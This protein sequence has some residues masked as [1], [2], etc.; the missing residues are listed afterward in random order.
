MSDLYDA[1]ASALQA[2]VQQRQ[3]TDWKSILANSLA[4]GAKGAMQGFAEAKPN[5]YG[6]QL[7]GAL[8][9]GLATGYGQQRQNK[10]ANQAM[11]DFASV[12][13]GVSPN[14]P[15]DLMAGLKDKGFNNSGNLAAALTLTDFENRNN[16]QNQFNL[17]N[18]AIGFDKGM[19][20]KDGQFVPIPSYNQIR[21]MQQFEGAAAT[22]QGRNETDLAYANRIARAKK[23]A[24]VFAEDRANRALNKSLQYRDNDEL[25]DIYKRTPTANWEDLSKEI[26]N[27]EI[28]ERNLNDVE[29]TFNEIKKLDAKALVPGSKEAAIYDATRARLIKI[30]HDTIKGNAAEREK[31]ELLPLFPNT[32]DLLSPEGQARM[33]ERLKYLED[34]LK[35]N[36][37]STPVLTRFHGVQN[38]Q[39]IHDFFRKEYKGM[40]STE[41]EYEEYL[42][43][44]AKHK[45][46][47]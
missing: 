20:F 44:S 6:S 29:K 14:S 2:E 13:S 22:A 4:Q 1:L 43:L 21:N 17:K 26:G 5:D 24:E 46:K 7:V 12:L 16:L 10:I 41:S 3:Q 9:G 40:N 37:A 27:I 15:S 35:S 47:K 39:K 23:E 38:K 30:L 31:A 25:Q 28:A 36:V 19:V 18:Q 11:G 33:D 45:G 34:F 8:A 32:M 42:R